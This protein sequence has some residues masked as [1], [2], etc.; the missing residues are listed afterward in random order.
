MIKIVM[1][2]CIL[3][4]LAILA[5][6]VSNVRPDGFFSSTIFTIAGILFSI[7][8]GLIVTFKPEGVKNKAYIKELRANILHV[9]NSFLCHFG[10]LTASYILNQYLS[11]P[12]YES[13]II[14]LTFS[15]PVFLCLLMLYSSLFFIVNFIAIYKLDNQIFDAVNQEQP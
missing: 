1:S 15:F 6:S 7:G 9:R 13:H 3:L 2:S 12:K 14:D 11:D 8:I 5:S 10:L 4:L